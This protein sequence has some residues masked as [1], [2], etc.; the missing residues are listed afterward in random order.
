MVPPEPANQSQEVEGAAVPQ[1]QVGR[2]LPAQRPAALVALG[3]CQGC[4]LLSAAL[5]A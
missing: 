1:S 5:E 3:L 2:C 4:H